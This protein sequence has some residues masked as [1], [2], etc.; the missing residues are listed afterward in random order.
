MASP[1]LYPRP[2]NAVDR[3]KEEVGHGPCFSRK[4]TTGNAFS[5]PHPLVYSFSDLR[6]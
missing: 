2:A 4:G 6:R 5:R 1:I 3:L